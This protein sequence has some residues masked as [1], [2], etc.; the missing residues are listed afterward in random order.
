MIDSFV[1]SK[2][3]LRDTKSILKILNNRSD[4][5]FDP[6][7]TTI[8]AANTSFYEGYRFLDVKDHSTFPAI[9]RYALYNKD[10][11]DCRMVNFSA[12]M[13]EQM[14]AD[15]PILLTSNNVLDYVRFYFD[16]VIGV[17]GKFSIVE[18]IDDI[19]W[20]DDPTAQMRRSLGSVIEDV[21]LTEETEESFQIGAT[22]LFKNA[23]FDMN[24]IVE[25][26]GTVEIRDQ[27]LLVKD[28]PVQ[29]LGLGH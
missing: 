28:M 27:D 11:K 13:V 17:H 2:L 10:S 19:P 23:L 3:G 29:D 8:M 15:T 12:A 25:R 4:R 20:L 14:N 6:E 1:F 22:V 24:V 5:S 16:V 18:A 21:E 26:D 9:K 7:K